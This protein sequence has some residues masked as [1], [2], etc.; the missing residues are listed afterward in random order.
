MIFNASG[1]RFRRASIAGALI[2]ALSGAG[3]MTVMTASPSRADHVPVEVN[4]VVKNVVMK[5]RSTPNGPNYVWDNFTMDFSFDTTG[6]DVSETDTVTIQLPSELRTREAYFDVTDKNT[7]GVAMKCVIPAGVGQTLHCAFTDYADE[8]VNMKGDIHVLADMTRAT[9]STHFEFTIGHDIVLPADI[10]NG[11]VIPNTNGYAPDTPWKFGWQLHEGHKERFTWEV[12]IPERNIHSGT[13]SVTDTFDTANGG[14]KLFNDPSTDPNAW[15]RTRLLKWNSL[16]DFKADPSHENYVESI[17]VGGTV[18]GGTFTMT[19]TSTG[20]V[21]SFPNSNSDAYYMIKYYTVLN[22]PEN[23]KPGSVFNNKADV[24][25]MT[26]ERTIA[27]ETVGWGDLESDRRP[28][29]PT[30]TTSTPPA[31]TVTPSPSESTTEATPSP[32]TSTTPS[33]KTSLAHTGAMTAPAIG[34]GALGLALGVA[35]MRRREQAS[36]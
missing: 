3:A 26:A 12:Y 16:D 36:A 29:P 30:P 18:N 15:Q 13:I 27:I 33:P 35:L 17:P 20:F 11:N 5:N 7:G 4:H 23:A 31:T 32:S 10:E 28:T 22:I 19:E 1:A 25:G 2:C 34:L 21:A 6:T 24:N 14:Y 9:T 8:H